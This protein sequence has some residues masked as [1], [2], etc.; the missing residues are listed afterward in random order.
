L[1]ARRVREPRAPARAERE[2]VFYARVSSKEQEKE[3]FSIPAQRR[4]L[5][6][7]ATKRSLRIVREFAD[8]ETAKRSGRTGFREM[9]AF[10]AQNRN[11]RI[12]LAEKTDR[13]YR[14]FRDLVTL[15]ELDLEI[16][17]VKEGVVL[18]KDSRSHE[19]FVHGIKVLMAK[20]YIDN[21]SEETRKGMVEKAEQGIYPSMAP[22]GYLNAEG[23]DGK[24]TIEPD[25]SMAP[26]ITRLFEWY[27][28]GNHSL[29][30]ATQMAKA[31]GLRSVNGNV[32]SK[33]CIHN[34]LRRR[35]YS[36]DFDWNGKTYAGSHVPLVSRELWNRVQAILD[37]RFEK[38]ARKAKH[39]FAFSRLI[40]CGHCGCSLVGQ[41]Q[42][43]QYVY[44]HCTGY[45]GKCS[46]PYVREEV[47]EERFADL[48]RGLSFDQ[49]V[50][51]WMSAALRESHA[52]EKRHHEEAVTRLKAQYGRLQ[53]RLHTLYDDRLDERIDAEFYDQKA[54]ELR[55]EQDRVQEAID[56]HQA[57]DRTYIDEGVQLLELASRAYELFRKQKAAEKRRLLNF[58]LSNCSWKNG[59]LTATFRQPFDMLATTNIAYQKKKAAGMA[60]SDLSENWLPIVDSFR[61][62]SLTPNKEMEALFQDL[63]EMPWAV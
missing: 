15:D 28:T 62:L 48:V 38:R 30:E 1:S 2:A 44:Y 29:R 55:A 7:Y 39:D 22:T 31:E 27:G 12:A 10:L 56:K 42:K 58:L 8:V 26:I 59:T 16:H 54:T 11:C 3:G 47:L 51:D 4:L 19:K 13:L 17:L 20:N 6:D 18:S 41:L 25:P 43:G 60:S 61:T 24:R 32:F 36:G 21:L 34:V 5:R 63:A 46:E 49:E 53:K 40:K 33:S 37:A 50:L 57:A 45:K 35:L 9:L 52:D 14:N 23:P